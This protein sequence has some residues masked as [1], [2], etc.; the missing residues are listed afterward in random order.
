MLVL[1]YAAGL[2]VS[3]LCGLKWRDLQ[4]RNGGGQVVVFGKGE[5]TRTILL[6]TP[7]WAKLLTLRVDAGDN[8]PVFR[9]RKKGHLTP[10]QVWRIVRKAALRAGIERAVS[11]HW[12]RHAHASHALDRGAPIHLVQVGLGHSSVAMT[13]RYLHARPTDSAA[14]YL[15]L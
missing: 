11:P 8:D 2:R 13:G 5:K 15:P 6:P 9:S 1:L 7:V 10:P 14:N 12:M 4:N 3:E